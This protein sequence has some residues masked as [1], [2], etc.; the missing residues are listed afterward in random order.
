MKASIEIKALALYV[1]GPGKSL[2]LL[3]VSL[4]TARRVITECGGCGSK[5]K[6]GGKVFI[7][8]KMVCFIK[9]LIKMTDI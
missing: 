7:K 9:D 4:N 8:G 5:T 6:T 1:V 2:A 3:V